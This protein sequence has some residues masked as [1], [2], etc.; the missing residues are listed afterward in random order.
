MLHRVILTAASVVALTVAASAADMYRPA[1]AMGGYK[2]IPYVGINWS[3]F[4][5]GINGGSAAWDQNW[6]YHAGFFG[7]QIGYNVQ[8]GNLVFGIETD[9]QGP[10]DSDYDGFYFGTVRGRVGYALN[11]ALVYG[12]GGYAYAGADCSGCSVDGWAAGGG[13]EY[14]FTP[15]WS[16]KGEYQHITLTEGGLE[17]GSDTFRVGVNFFVGGGYDALR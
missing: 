4:Y 9:L 12:T 5:A 13:L 3:G 8:R 7:G 1:P 10:T 2:D 15:S 6:D 16:I 14:K 11:R 17:E